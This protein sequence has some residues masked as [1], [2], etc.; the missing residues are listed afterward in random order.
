MAKE[1][2]NPFE[3]EANKWINETHRLKRKQFNEDAVIKARIAAESDA[4][5]DL[6][7]GK[8]RSTNDVLN[9]SK[10]NAL[11]FKQQKLRQ[12]YPGNP[13]CSCGCVM[14]ERTNK[15]TGD[16]FWGC[17]N[18]PKCIGTAKRKRY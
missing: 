11:H 18:Y 15:S 16:K 1:E 10:D 12:S 2:T 3:E 9:D 7:I 13:I 8:I 5:D 4:E 6:L 14:L 17:S